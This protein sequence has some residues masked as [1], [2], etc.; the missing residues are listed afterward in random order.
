MIVADGLVTPPLATSRA[1]STFALALVAVLL[2]S[3]LLTSLGLSFGNCDD[4][5]DLTQVELLD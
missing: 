3:V 2:G 1:R 5:A 4:D